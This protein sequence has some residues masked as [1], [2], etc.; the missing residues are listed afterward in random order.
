MHA[1]VLK[2]SKKSLRPDFRTLSR[3]ALETLCA[4]GADRK[5]NLRLIAPNQRNQRLIA[6]GRPEFVTILR[7]GLGTLKIAF[8][9][10][11]TN[12]HKRATTNVRN[13]LVFLFLFSFGLFS[14]LQTK[15]V[16][17]PLNSKKKSQ[18]KRYENV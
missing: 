3:K 17:K 11:R 4:A 8:N 9:R 16:V 7:L 6:T 5:T 1:G 13:G 15:T 2:E 18:R 12:R 14:S 10:R